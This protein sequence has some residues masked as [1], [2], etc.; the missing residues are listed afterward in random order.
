[1]DAPAAEPAP[2][3]RRRRQGQRSALHAE[4]MRSHGAADLYLYAFPPLAK[5]VNVRT[6]E[7]IEVLAVCLYHKEKSI[8]SPRSCMRFLPSPLP[9]RSAPPNPHSP[10]G[11]ASQIL[12][13]WGCTGAGPASLSWRTNRKGPDGLCSTEP[14]KADCA[15]CGAAGPVPP[16]ARCIHR[17]DPAAPTP[18]GGA[19]A[20]ATIAPRQSRR[21]GPTTPSIFQ[22]RL[23][24]ALTDQGGGR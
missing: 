17:V 20:A 2:T 19:D 10:P 13:P 6:K 21:L 4:E 14:T 23:R 22:A 12:S 24:R 18:A 11:T 7:A 15:P 16:R 3:S 5:T 9:R 8:H 1:M